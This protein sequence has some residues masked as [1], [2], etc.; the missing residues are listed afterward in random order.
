L[1]QPT[2]RQSVYSHYGLTSGAA[3]GGS[4]SPGGRTIG[5]SEQPTD[6]GQPHSTDPN[7]PRSG[8][9]SGSSGLGTD[10]DPNR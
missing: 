9:S 3:T 4:Y 7:R 8:S 6:S 1:S 2:W 5:G 10:R